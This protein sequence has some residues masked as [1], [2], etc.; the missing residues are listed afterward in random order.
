MDIQNQ[1]AY[2]Q[3]VA[4]RGQLAAQHAELVKGFEDYEASAS[5]EG[6]S[7]PS[8]LENKKQYQ[9]ILASQSLRPRIEELDKAIENFDK[10]KADAAREE[11]IKQSGSPILREAGLYNNWVTADIVEKEFTDPRLKDVT[12]VGANELRDL[13]TR[14]VENMQAHMSPNIKQEKLDL[15]VLEQLRLPR[16]AQGVE[17]FVETPTIQNVLRSDQSPGGQDWTPVRVAPQPLD[18]MVY[19]GGMMGATSE[20]FTDDGV[21]WKFPVLDDTSNEGELLANQGASAT[22]QDL[23]ELDEKTMKASIMSSKSVE[24]NLKMLQD[25]SFDVD[26]LVTRLLERRMAR[27]WNRQFTTGDGTNQNSRGFITD[28]EDSGIVTAMNTLFSGDELLE[29]KSSVNIG[30]FEDEGSPAGLEPV[31]G[32]VLKGWM[33]H[34]A[35]QGIT[36]RLK[37]NGQYL[38]RLGNLGISQNVPSLLAGMPYRINNHMDGVIAAGAADKVAAYGNFGYYMQRFMNLRINARFFDSGTVLGFKNRYIAF[39]IG[40]GRFVGGFPNTANDACE[41]VKTLTVKA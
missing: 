28:A 23:T 19:F 4:H 33:F 30:Y 8:D 25:V 13:V 7:A 22:A 10:A 38:W 40:Y 20:M 24:V 34:Q 31:G 36:E 12:C 6:D 17:F 26:R 15:K 37:G 3:A 39:T 11:R 41:A 14:Q 29:L 9:R 16:N 21:D 18:R 2:D 35:V 1:N 32:N 27:G 5:L